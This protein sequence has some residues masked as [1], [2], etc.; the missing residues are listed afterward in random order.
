MKNIITIQHTQSE[1]HTN[2]MIGSWADWDLTPLGIEQANR[3]GERLAKELKGEKYTIYAS[4]L[5]RTK[6]T[7]E[8]VASYLNVEPIYTELLREFH[9][10]EAIGKSKAW[11]RE[12]AIC[13]M[14]PNT[15]DWPESVDDKPFIG[16]ESK[17]GVWNRLLPFY[18]QIVESPEENLIIVSHDGTLSIFFAMWLGL[19]IEMLNKCSL[20]GKAGGVSFLQEHAN[21]NRSIARL[22]DLS[23]VYEQLGH[24]SNDSM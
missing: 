7:A 18:N 1:Q 13:K 3:I 10:G 15:V 5:L 6:H 9:L 19:D 12:N 24:P 2:K 22:N 8:I 14:W 16:A 17:R 11:A 21:K 20:F 23:Y 4:D